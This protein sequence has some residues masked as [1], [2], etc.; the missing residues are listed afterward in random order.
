VPTIHRREAATVQ[1]VSSVPE[2]RTEDQARRLKRYLVTMAIRTA[3]FVLLVVIDEWYRWIFAA[4]AVFLPFFAVVAANAVTP[5]V[6]GRVQPVLPR[7]DDTLLLTR[8]PDSS[9]GPGSPTDR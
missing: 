2:S 7:V 9:A 4:G 8:E 5:R 3:C 6:R 1:S